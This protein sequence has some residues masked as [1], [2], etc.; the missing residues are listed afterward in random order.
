MEKVVKAM[1]A[2]DHLSHIDAPDVTSGH[3]GMVDPSI[4][5]LG[6]PE[7]ADL[8]EEGSSPSL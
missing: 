7:G 8:I 6:P 3:G 2:F 4:Q 5:A 1:V